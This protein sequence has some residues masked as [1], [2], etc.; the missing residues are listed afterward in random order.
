MRSR[1]ITDSIMPEMTFF[2]ESCFFCIVID[3]MMAKAHYPQ[4]KLRPRQRYLGRSCIA[5][6]RRSM[7]FFGAA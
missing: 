1:R 3:A 6:L 5:E 2:G 7:R 4:A